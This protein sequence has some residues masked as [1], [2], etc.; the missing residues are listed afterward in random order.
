V[1]ALDR[2]LRWMEA[3]NGLMAARA[4]M[5]RIAAEIIRK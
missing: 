2:T 1:N 5:A 3:M 4:E